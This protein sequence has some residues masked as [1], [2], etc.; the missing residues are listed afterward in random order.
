MQRSAQPAPE[1]PAVPSAPAPVKTGASAAADGT[2]G[3]AF[4]GDWPRLA[5]QL[6][7]G[8]LPKQLAQQSELVGFDGEVMTLAIAPGAK[9]LGEKPYRDKL[10]AA[11]VE[12]FGKAVR[13]SVQLGGVR[14][15]TAQD[16]A[17]QAVDKDEFVRG[18]MQTFDATIVES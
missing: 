17:A 4:D 6:K 10:Q 13:L 12:Y 9:H 5:G 3:P 14:G 18:M 1:S 11:L 16:R 7:I 8:G 2:A 15:D